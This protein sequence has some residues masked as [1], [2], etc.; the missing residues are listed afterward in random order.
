[1]RDKCLGLNDSGND[2]MEEVTMML[3]FPKCLGL[4]MWVL[5]KGPKKMP[6]VVEPASAKV[7]R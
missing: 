2:F 7:W 4:G 6:E 1:M 5:E 3:S